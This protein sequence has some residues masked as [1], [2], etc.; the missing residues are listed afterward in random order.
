[1]PF[2]RYKARTAQGVMQAGESEAESASRLAEQLRA[3]GWVVLGIEEARGRAAR[4]DG[5]PPY[6]NPAWLMPVTSLDIE[7]GFRQLASMLRSGVSILAAL[8]TVALQS[9]CPRAAIVWLDLESRI[10]RGTNLSDAMGRHP[11]AFGEYVT[12]LVRVGEHSGEMDV[13][14][15]RAADHLELH[16]DVRMMVANALIYP[17]IATLMAVGVSA[18]LVAV[19]IP[20]ISTF[21]ETSGAKLPALTQSLIDFSAWIRLNGFSV[22]AVLAGCVLSWLAI[23]RHPAGREAQDVLLIRIP[24]VGRILRLSQTAIF[25]RGTGLLIDSGVTLLDALGIVEKLLGNRR[26]AR[27]IGD[28]RLSVMRGEPLA[29]ALERA[30]EFFPLL[31][32]MT[33][34]AE[35]T[36][37]LGPTLDEVARFHEKLLVI[38]IKRFSVLVEPVV[39]ILTGV[40]VGFVYIAFF[41]A[42]FSLVSSVK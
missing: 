41:M 3:S 4:G 31:V 24:V 14:M 16:R 34:V 20:K 10:R 42:L 7:L 11:R 15:T 21:L 27:R 19:V 29:A 1:M 8:K 33:A 35:T 6:W 30:R 13:S 2:F 38:S 5:L 40:I 9:G 17:C 37:T 23:R 12:Q 25:A 22:L 36:G 26:F 28:A 18:Y 39:I 32:R